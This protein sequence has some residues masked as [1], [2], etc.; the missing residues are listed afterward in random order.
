MSVKYGVLEQQLIMLYGSIAN[1]ANTK[2]MQDKF[3]H[4]IEELQQHK[5]TLSWDFKDLQNEVGRV[6]HQRDILQVEVN[7]L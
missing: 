2:N 7:F 6:V 5:E 4:E 1:I 3:E